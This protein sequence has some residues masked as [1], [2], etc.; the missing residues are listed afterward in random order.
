MTAENHN[1]TFADLSS[2]RV[3]LNT[4]ENL[5]AEA[6]ELK[7]HDRTLRSSMLWSVQTMAS[8]AQKDIEQMEAAGA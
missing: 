6:M 5:V 1:P 7:D 8:T 2:I 3:L 4:I